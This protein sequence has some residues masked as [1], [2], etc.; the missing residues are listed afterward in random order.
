MLISFRPH[1]LGAMS[2]KCQTKELKANL[3]H[4]SREKKIILA[5]SNSQ[6]R[7]SRTRSVST[8]LRAL[9][10]RDVLP[11]GNRSRVTIRHSVVLLVKGNRKRKAKKK[12]ESAHNYTG[13]P[14]LK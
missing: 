14:S 12:K 8:N 3:G 1:N 7:R 10:S 2:S 13:S 6:D 9:S 11:A 5:D 4:N